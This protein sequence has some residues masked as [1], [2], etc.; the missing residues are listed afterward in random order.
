MHRVKLDLAVIPLGLLTRMESA[1]EE[2]TRLRGT[3]VALKGQEPAMS[4]R[5]K[6]ETKT[7]W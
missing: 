1:R 5:E 4:R 3:L 7:Q 6:E 2:F